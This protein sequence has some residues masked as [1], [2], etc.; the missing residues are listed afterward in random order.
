[1]TKEDQGKS[2]SAINIT[3]SELNYYIE[4]VDQKIIDLVH[5]NGKTGDV[6]EPNTAFRADIQV[7]NKDQESVKKRVNEFITSKYCQSDDFTISLDSLTSLNYEE[8]KTLKVEEDDINNRLIELSMKFDEAHDIKHV[9]KSGCGKQGEELKVKKTA[10][11]KN[12]KDSTKKWLNQLDDIQFNFG[13]VKWEENW[14][15]LI[16]ESE[17]SEEEEKEEFKPKGELKERILAKLIKFDSFDDVEDE[18]SVVPSEG[19]RKEDHTVRANRME[20]KYLQLDD[21]DVELYTNIE[22]LKEDM[23]AMM[24]Q[25]ENHKK[26][27]HNENEM[28]II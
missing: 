5:K 12:D 28:Q 20:I 1:M 27:K 23:C 19:L 18:D 10:G 15:T 11:L 21:F 16:S 6:D 9:L 22:G 2:N 24:F 8:F 25:D 13:F 14:T 4:S 26:V 3:V 7:L 17:D